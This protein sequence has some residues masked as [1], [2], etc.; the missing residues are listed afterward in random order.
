MP[1][2]MA[3]MKSVHVGATPKETL[4]AS[5]AGSRTRTAPTITSS[6]WVRKSTT[7]SVTLI[8]VDSFAP[9][10]LTPASRAMTTQAAMMSPG[11]DLSAFAKSK[12]PPM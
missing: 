6:T 1:I 8:P 11:L 4:S 7:A 3:R 2:G 5:W 12:T 10:T 9:K